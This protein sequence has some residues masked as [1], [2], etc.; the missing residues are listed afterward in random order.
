MTTATRRR[1]TAPPKRPA[2]P[3]ATA[4]PT[5]AAADAH[6][7]RRHAQPSGKI[8][9]SLTRLVDW[10]ERPG[11]TDTTGQNSSAS[12]KIALNPGAARPL[13]V[14]AP[15]HPALRESRM[16]LR[17][18]ARI[19]RGNSSSLLLA[20][21]PS[22][23]S[24]PSDASRRTPASALLQSVPLIARGRIQAPVRPNSEMKQRPPPISATDFVLDRL[25]FP[26]LRSSLSPNQPL[27][28]R[29]RRSGV[30]AG[31]NCWGRSGI[32]CRPLPPSIPS[33]SCRRRS[34]APSNHHRRRSILSRRRCRSAVELP[35]PLAAGLG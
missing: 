19:E 27:K 21:K 9:T 22:E 2:D 25:R 29:P 11:G 14:S 1:T 26:L 7:P 15:I 28:K 33:T 30:V 18:L 12:R 20:A 32:S 13:L 3:A 8:P 31:Q 4:T 10:E 23:A 34:T 5:A 6:H 16:A 35:P 17:P 24:A